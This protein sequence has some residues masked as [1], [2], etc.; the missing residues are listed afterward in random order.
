M[1]VPMKQCMPKLLCDREMP[2]MVSKW[3]PLNMAT[4]FYVKMTVGS[5][6]F[7]VESASQWPSDQFVHEDGERLSMVWWF[8]NFGGAR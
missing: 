6:G 8:Y 5:I 1:C 4:F 3:Q 2:T 7:P